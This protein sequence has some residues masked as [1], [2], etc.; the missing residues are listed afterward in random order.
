MT[1]PDY[2]HVVIIADRSGS[3]REKAADTEQGLAKVLDDL[4]AEPFR[5]T[6][7]LYDFDDEYGIVYEWQEIAEVP[8]YKLIARGMTAL[9]DAVGKTITS[10]GE[11]LAKLDEAERPSAV[12]VVIATDG[13]ENSSKEYSLDQVREMV[14]HQRDVYDWRFM[15]IGVDIDAFGTSRAMGIPDSGSLYAVGMNLPQAYASASAQV[16]RLTVNSG[17]SYSMAERSAAA[18][19]ADPGWFAGLPGLA[20]TEDEAEKDA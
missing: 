16:S 12:I 6:V 11:H 7:S 19:D 14:T 2:R 8:H 15:F 9:N 13:Q 5:T 4:A 17:A 3:M 1:N 18:G 10:T 20:K